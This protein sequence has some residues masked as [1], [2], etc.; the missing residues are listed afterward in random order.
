AAEPKNPV[1]QEVMR[2]EKA[3][4]WVGQMHGKHGLTPL[5][6]AP[7]FDDYFYD[8]MTHSD[9]DDYWKQPDLNW[10]LA[11]DKTADIPM[12]HITGWYDS[13]TSGTIANYVGLSKVKKSPI[14]LLVGPWTHGGNTRSFSGNVEYGPEAAIKD[15]A[16][17]FH[18]RWYDHFLK[19]NSA[20]AIQT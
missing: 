12:L 16:T 5:A 7:N 4:D 15:F 19:N 14:R 11:F 8:M 1:A 6:V 3:A 10:S 20:S 17:D 13:Y 9:Y 2:H 18:L